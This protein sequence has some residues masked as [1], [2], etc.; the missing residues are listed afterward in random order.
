VAGIAADALSL[1][2]EASEDAHPNEYMAL[3]RG[4]PAGDLGVDATGYVITDLLFV[5]GTRSSPT[6]ATVRS[7]LVPNDTRSLGSVHS[8]PNGVLRPSD[9][10]LAA[11]SNGRA[12]IIIGAPYG[13]D[14]W[15]AFDRD[16]DPRDLP[17]FDVELADPESF[18]DDI[19]TEGL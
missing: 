19:D 8:H 1:A 12:H 2:R 18:F 6:Q 4:E 17:V 7:N 15:R 16:G 14:D 3:L 9:A 13:P 10:D 5:P 11:F